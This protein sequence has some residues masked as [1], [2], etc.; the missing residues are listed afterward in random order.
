MKTSQPTQ[1]MC[2]VLHYHEIWTKVDMTLAVPIFLWIIPAFGE[3]TFSTDIMNGFKGATQERLGFKHW[4]RKCG[5]CPGTCRIIETMSAPTLSLL[6]RCRKTKTSMNK[7]QK[8][9]KMVWLAWATR[10]I[11][12]WLNHHQVLLLPPST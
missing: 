4:S 6:P 3:E 2:L 8:N 11:N 10:T 7:S 12:G 1:K 5:K 9:S